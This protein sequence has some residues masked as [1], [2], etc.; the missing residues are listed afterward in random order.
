MYQK[1]APSI[2]ATLHI[3]CPTECVTV[4]KH[5]IRLT[6]IR[7]FVSCWGHTPRPSVDPYSTLFTT[8]DFIGSVVSTRIIFALRRHEWSDAAAILLIRR[9]YSK[10]RYIL[11][12][13]TLRLNN[14]SDCTCRRKL[15]T[16]EYIHNPSFH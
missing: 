11:I 10:T 14:P 12:A 3:L 4:M 8:Q 15:F 16:Y 1:G 7:V 13:K 9:V 5:D 6:N 2:T